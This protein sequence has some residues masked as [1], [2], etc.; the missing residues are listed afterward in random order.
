MPV[1]SIDFDDFL[2]LYGSDITKDEF[3]QNIPNIGADVERVIDNQIDIEFFPDRPDLYS[4]EG[5]AR[6]MR[7]FIGHEPGLRKYNVNNSDIKLIVDPSVLDVRPWVVC[8]LVRNVVFTDPFVKSIM[9]VQEKLHLTLGRKRKKVSIGIHDFDAVKPPFTYAA[10][11]PESVQFIPLGMNDYMDM[12]EVLRK[13]EKG[14]EYRWILDGMDKYPL[15]T[16][17][18]HEVLSFPPIINGIATTVTE[19]SSNIFLDVTGLDYKGCN[20]ALNII[21]SLLAERGGDVESVSVEY[22]DKTLVTPDL[23][24]TIQRLD[25][26][27]TNRFLGINFSPKDVINHLAKMGYHAQPVNDPNI[28]QLDVSIPAYRSDI[29]HPID[30]VEDVAIGAGYDSFTPVQPKAMTYGKV[31][32][33]ELF[34]NQLRSILIGLSFTEI[35]TLS[36]SNQKEQFELFNINPESSQSPATVTIKNPR[37]EDFTMLRTSLLPALLTTLR[38][39]QHR[40][41]PQRIFEISDVVIPSLSGKEF[42]NQRHFAGAVIHSK[43]N[44]T[45]I[46]STVDTILRLIA[47]DKNLDLKPR[48]HPAFIP[49]RCVAVVSNANQTDEEEAELGFFGELHPSTISNFDLGYPVTVFEFNAEAFM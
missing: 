15:I 19:N 13:H 34:S 12:E 4:V 28:N 20:T 1:I 40:D 35:M 46:K 39:N 17:A 47:R 9:D 42:K 3:I 33:P 14:I 48:I 25:I 38:N 11:D 31:R 21:A 18:D 7:A 43:T 37:T 5:V 16:D 30:L 32:P 6:A 2:D 27:Y 44:F 24:P 45:E 29:L 26:D 23:G 8:G 10:V 41:L 49:G 22:P 36:L